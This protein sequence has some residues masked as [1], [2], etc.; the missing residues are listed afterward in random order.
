[1][2]MKKKKKAEKLASIHTGY[3]CINAKQSMSN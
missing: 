2:R 1:M 3:A